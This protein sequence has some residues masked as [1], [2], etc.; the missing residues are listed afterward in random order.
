MTVLNRTTDLYRRIKDSSIKIEK[1]KPVILILL[2]MTLFVEN[3]ELEITKVLYCGFQGRINNIIVYGWRFPP[4]INS[5]F[6]PDLNRTFNEGDGPDTHLKKETLI[7]HWLSEYYVTSEGPKYKGAFGKNN[8]MTI[9]E[10]WLSGCF[11][12]D[13][14]KILAT[15]RGIIKNDAV[16]SGSENTA[17]TCNVAWNDQIY[18]VYLTSNIFNPIMKDTLFIW[19][20]GLQTKIKMLQRGEGPDVDMPLKKIFGPGE[21]L[22]PGQSSD[23]REQVLISNKEELGLSKE[24]I[25]RCYHLPL[26]RYDTT[27]RDPRYRRMCDIQD[28][29][30]IEFGEERNAVSNASIILLKT[31]PTEEVVVGNHTDTTE[32]RKKWWEDMHGILDRYSETDLM[33]EDHRKFIPDAIQK[34]SEFNSFDE[35]RKLFLF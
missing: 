32:I 8:C 13:K 9:S 23:A 1:N 3:T 11:I 2:S 14:I 20:N 35:Y 28:G 21:H 27:N 10:V 17:W 4:T 29:V 31:D 26:G 7:K 25:M 33:L 34:I 18:C 24:T 12:G 6:E 16:L 5:T 22:E 19:D 15:K 30:I